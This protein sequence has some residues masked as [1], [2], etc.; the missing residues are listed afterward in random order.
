MKPLRILLAAAGSTAAM[1]GLTAPA[2]SQLDPYLGQITSYA[3]DY[4]PQ[5]WAPASGQQIPIQQNTALY[6]L[7]GVQYGGNGATYFN[8]PNLNGRHAAGQGQGPGLSNVT[9]GEIFG[10]ATVMLTVDQLPS[11]NH[12]F[13]ASSQ[14]PDSPSPSGASYATYPPQS[15]AYAAAGLSDVALNVTVVQPA[16]NSSPMPVR[17]PYLA[18]TWCVAMQGIYPQR[19]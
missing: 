12:S 1:A 14:S 8:L 7:Y 16:G 6:S 18:M 3:F 4:C 19:P 10:H 9:Q 15:V 17:Q 2:F 5:G 11:H 13:H